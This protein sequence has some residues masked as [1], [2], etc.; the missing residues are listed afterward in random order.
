[1]SLTN[2]D[3]DIY[4]LSKCEVL[5]E[6]GAKR[7]IGE[8]WRSSKVVLVFL[9]HF[10]CIACRAHAAQ[11]WA[12]RAVYE[13]NNS[14]LV[15]IGNGA[16]QYIEG[17]KRELG[18]EEAQIFTD[19]TLLSFRFSGLKR[20][21]L[22]LVSVATA[23]NALKLYKEG[24]RQKQLGAQGDH[25]QLGGILVITPENKVTYHFVSESL[26]DTPDSNE[27][28]ARQL[29]AKDQKNIE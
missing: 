19:P 17:F 4:N 2:I 13:K 29:E 8:F 20:S 18:L 21:I 26:G 24:H 3:I 9:R 28:H 6:N 14:K 16:P 1:M 10:A 25:L 5:D 12:H 7:R 22:G 11:V 15:F 23:K 27:F